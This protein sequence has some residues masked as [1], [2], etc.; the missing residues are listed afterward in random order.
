MGMGGA[1]AAMRDCMTI[2]VTG[3]LGQTDVQAAANALASY[4]AQ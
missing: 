3:A 2:A 1:A 4:A